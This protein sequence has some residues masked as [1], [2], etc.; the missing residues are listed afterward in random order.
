MYIYIDIYFGRNFALPC[1]LIFMRWAWCNM[2]M[3][4]WWAG[5]HLTQHDL[6]NYGNEEKKP[7]D[8]TLGEAVKNSISSIS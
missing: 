6:W 7:K 4:G 3:M 8:V 5:C 1:T 2:R